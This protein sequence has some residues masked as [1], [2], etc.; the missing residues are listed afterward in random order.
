MRTVK[1]RKELIAAIKSGERDFIV[2]GKSLILQCKVASKFNK[3]KDV[4]KEAVAAAVAPAASVCG[5]TTTALISITAIVIVGAIAI[6]G[7]LKELEVV[8]EVEDVKGNKG[9]IKVRKPIE[10]TP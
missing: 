10:R 5:I 7:V 6:I 8:I 3:V 1:N 2:E 9:R 4:P